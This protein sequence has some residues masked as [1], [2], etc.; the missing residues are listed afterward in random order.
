[1]FDF[2]IRHEYWFAAT[3]LALAM[4]GMGATLKLRD[5]VAVIKQPRALVFGLI[6]Q[7]LLV[8]LF[9]WA[10]IYL[11]QPAVGL[12]VGLALV[13]A[14]PGGTMSNVFT[15]LARGH[16][17]L[18]IALTAICSFLC[19]V[20]TPIVLD[21]L[22][23]AQLPGE[24]DM[25][26]AKIALEITLILM[27]PLVI[28]M[29]VLSVW[30][31]GAPRFSRICI[32]TSIFIIILIVVGAT[33]AGRVDIEKFAGS[34][35]LIL[36]AFVAGLATFSWFVPRLMGLNWPDSTAINIEV[37]FRNG[38]LGLLIKASLFPAVVGIV[39]PVGDMVLFTV[40]LYGA[41]VFPVAAAQV[42]LHGK[43]NRRLAA[44][45]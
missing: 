12:A 21:L 26:A 4:L 41:L 39:D 15:F 17:A 3:Q 10:L 27:L 8:P 19:L 14:I 24:F 44:S 2:Y 9:A 11:T 28:G 25:P 16:V 20:T 18:S 23:S 37:T 36:L 35:I 1:M 29:G 42:W 32:R 22:I 45:A 13:A 33:G 5:F 6:V 43:R 31:N 30:P 34:E 40:L 38:N 7:A